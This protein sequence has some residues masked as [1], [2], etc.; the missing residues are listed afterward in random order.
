MQGQLSEIDIRS[1]LQ[2]I[3]LGQRTGELYVETY[4][5][6]SHLRTLDRVEPAQSW[7]MFFLN[8]QIVYAGD[9]SGNLSRLR[10]YLHAQRLDSSLD[11]TVVSA[12]AS[13]NS[14]EYGC[15]WTLLERHVLSPEQGR[16]L[17][18]NMVHETLFDLLSLHQGGFIFK[19]SAALSPQLMTLEIE[20][21]VVKTMKQIQEWK[22][23]HSYIQSPQQC[24]V[25]L[26]PQQL[27]DMMPPSA[28]DRLSKWMDGRTS[29]RQISRY[30]SRDLLTV[31]KAIY[32]HIQKGLIQ[33]TTD[34]SDPIAPP[35]NTSEIW[36]ESMVPRVVCID[37]GAAIRQT[38]EEILDSSG[39]EVT[40]IGN[41]L[42]ALSLLFQLN[43]DLIL[44]DIAMPELEGYE[45]CAML[46]QSTAFRQTPIVMLTGKDGFIDRVRAGM[47]GATDY[48]TKPFGVQELLTL[49][50]KYVG[51]GNPQRPLPEKLL[52]EA[53]QDEL[54]IDS[55]DQSSQVSPSRP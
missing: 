46:R 47:S 9:T 50:E 20:P 6:S 17:L 49:V 19:L 27:Q 30:L 41:P 39:Y 54:E 11:T 26:E 33:L 23:F 34:T 37:D 5:S 31:T 10:D 3:E 4:R 35:S 25:I 2:L 48:L 36:Q 15:L 51:S 44:C 45:L 14:P 53:I 55:P 18:Q 29:L 24:P 38:V 42:K 7:L 43:P 21:L 22:Q 40:S 32:P 12:I 16:T 28:F 13:F 52:A 1:I 8:G